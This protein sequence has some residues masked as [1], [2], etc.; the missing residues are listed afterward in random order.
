MAAK[1][2]VEDLVGVSGRS[3]RVGGATAAVAGG[4]PKD[5]VKTVA[6][7]KSD[8]VDEYVRAWVAR[9]GNVSEKM[10]FGRALLT[11]CC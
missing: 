11:S 5:I 10:G 2:G 9:Y 1:I 8:A 4:V 7:W 3:M 6:G